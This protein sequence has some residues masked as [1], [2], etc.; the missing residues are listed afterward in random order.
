MQQGSRGRLG[1]DALVRPSVPLGEVRVARRPA[2]AGPGN[3][4]QL[5]SLAQGPS[6]GAGVASEQGSSQVGQDVPSPLVLP[7]QPLLYSQSLGAH[8]RHIHTPR[9]CSWT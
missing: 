9:G 1:E 7:V 8:T 3:E 4:E 5:S 2:K 6:L